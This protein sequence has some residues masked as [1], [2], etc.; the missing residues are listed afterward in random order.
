M[1]RNQMI[2]TLLGG[3]VGTIIEIFTGLGSAATVMIALG[4]VVGGMLCGGFFDSN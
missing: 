1:T 2:G 3:V 4:C